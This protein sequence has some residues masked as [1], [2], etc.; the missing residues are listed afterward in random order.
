MK[1]KKNIVDDISMKMLSI[2]N[3]QKSITEEEILQLIEELDEIDTCGRDGRTLLIHAACYNMTEIANHLISKNANINTQDDLGYSP[4]HAAVVAGNYEMVKLLLSCGAIVNI[5]DNWGNT[6]LHRASTK[7]VEIIDLLLQYGANPNI[8][9]DFGISAV[10]TFQ[11][12]PNILVII[13]K[14]L[15]ENQI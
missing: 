4:L 12:F 1:K 13:N 14:H 15:G 5:F 2:H 7:C 9:N 6:P 8:C 10:Q 3:G 11:A